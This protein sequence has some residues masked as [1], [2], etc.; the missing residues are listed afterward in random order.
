[1]HV[2]KNKAN[3]QGNWPIDKGGESFEK[4]PPTIY[5]NFTAESK[6]PLHDKIWKSWKY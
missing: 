4:M 6:N 5:Y 2:K 1:M 3:V